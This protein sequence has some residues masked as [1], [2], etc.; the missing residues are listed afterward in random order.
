MSL[1][2]NDCN[3]KIKALK[4]EYEQKYHAPGIDINMRIVHEQSIGPHLYST[5]APQWQR[6]VRPQLAFSALHKMH[7]KA[8]EKGVPLEALEVLTRKN[9]FSSRH[10]DQA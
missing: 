5:L 4:R 10:P 8:K 6:P 3:D 7:A 9:Q 1:G 2:H